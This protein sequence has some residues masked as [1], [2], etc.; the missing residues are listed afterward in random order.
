MN[1]MVA[2]LL[3]FFFPFAADLTEELFCILE[4]AFTLGI[5]AA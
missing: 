5:D 3:T 1:T 2:Y 4:N